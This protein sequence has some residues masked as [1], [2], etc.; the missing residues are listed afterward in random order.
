[1]QEREIDDLLQLDLTGLTQFQ[2]LHFV[3]LSITKE[4]AKR[5][6]INGRQSNWQMAIKIESCAKLFV[7]LFFAA[8]SLAQLCPSRSLTQNTIIVLHRTSSITWRASER[9]KER[10]ERQVV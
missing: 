3:N 6:S 10:V 1:M 4:S 2:A 7:S 8:R 5:A 9:W